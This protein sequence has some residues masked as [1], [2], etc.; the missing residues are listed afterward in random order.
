LPNG[1]RPW[2]KKLIQC[3]RD[4]LPSSRDVIQS[5]HDVARPLRD[6]AQ[7]SR[8]VAQLLLGVYLLLLGAWQ[9]LQELRNKHF[10]HE[11]VKFGRVSGLTANFFGRGEPVQQSWNQ[12]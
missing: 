7:P 10:W 2:P 12:F 9:S 11:L 8:D 1:F 6:V 4:A 3:P 5:L